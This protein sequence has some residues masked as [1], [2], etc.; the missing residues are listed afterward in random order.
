MPGVQRLSVDL[1]VEAAR[2]AASLGIPAIAVFPNTARDLRT[3]DGR[4]AFNPDN[5]VC[6]A[7][8]AIKAAVPDLGIICDVALDPYT[9]HGHDGLCCATGASSTTRRS[10][11]W[12]ARRWS[13]SRP[14]ATSSRRPT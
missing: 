9:S 1:A 14:A 4:E 2:E 11:R 10:T 5:L 3:E 12:C 6:R 8:R 7:V 13:R